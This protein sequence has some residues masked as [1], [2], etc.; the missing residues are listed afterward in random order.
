MINCNSGLGAAGGKLII[1]YGYDT[2]AKSSLVWSQMRSLRGVALHLINWGLGNY[3]R[4]LLAHGS[5]TRP[6]CTLGRLSFVVGV[7]S[8]GQL[9]ATNDQEQAH[10][11]RDQG[12]LREECH[13]HSVK[14]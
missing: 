14:G 7:V 5:L 9:V 2:L 1:G 10:P 13:D 8:N 12:K 6:G 3:S 11:E 4:A